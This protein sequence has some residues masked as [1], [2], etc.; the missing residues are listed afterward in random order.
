MGDVAE[1]AGRPPVRSVNQQSSV[2]GR[3]SRTVVDVTTIC[4]HI[5][6]KGGDRSWRERSSHSV[7]HARPVRRL[8]SKV[9]PSACRTIRA[10]GRDMLKMMHGT[11]LSIVVLTAVAIDCASTGTGTQRGP[12]AR[13]H[14]LARRD[15]GWQVDRRRKQPPF[16]SDHLARRTDC[17]ASRTVLG[18]G[19]GGDQE[20]RPNTDLGVDVRRRDRPDRP[21]HV[22]GDAI[23]ASKRRAC[24]HRLRARRRGPSNY[25]LT[26]RK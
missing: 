20:W 8:S 4:P 6:A 2:W 11:W 26:R 7:P 22:E 3:R 5:E 25:E 1:G 23:G 12:R 10:R 16:H 17:R 13:R 14:G 24:P 18:A 15:L 19:E 9:T 21:A